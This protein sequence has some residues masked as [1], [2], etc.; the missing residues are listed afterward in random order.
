MLNEDGREA[1]DR[2]ED[3]AVDD[4]GALLALLRRLALGRA[5]G[6]RRPRRRRVLE[7]EPDRQLEVELD[8]GALVLAAEGVVDVEVDLGA[9][10]GAVLGVELPVLARRLLVGVERRGE[11]PLRLV[12]RLELAHVLLGPGG[13]EHV[14]LEAELAVDEVDE[15]QHVLDL[16][17][18][19]LLLAEDVRVVLLEPAHA[20][21]AG[22]GAA[23]LVAV[24][25][26]EV[27]EAPGQLAE[28]AL[29]LGEH[30]AVAGAV[31]GL[32]AEL[33]LLHLEDEHVLAV[34]RG[35]ARRLPQLHV[36]H[37]GRDDLA[38]A[39]LEVLL[40]DGLHQP[41]VDARAVRQPE[42]A[43][44]A[45]LVEEE[46]LLL[47]ADGAVVALLGLLDAEEVLLE[48]L[49]VGEGHAVHAL[50][51]VVASLALP[52]GG[53]VL[54]DGECLDL[55]RVGHVRPAAQVHQVAAAVGRA[56]GA[57]GH[58]ALE[59]VHLEVVVLEH[60]ERLVL[61]HLHALEG[62][63]A[64]DHLVEELLDVLL[65]GAGNGGAAAVDVVVE[66]I[67]DGGADAEVGAVFQ[68]Q[69]EAENVRAGVPE[70][71]ATERVVELAKLKLAVPF[72]RSL[73]VPA[74]SVDLGDHRVLSQALG[75]SHC[76]VEW[77]GLALNS[78]LDSAVRQLNIDGVLGE[79]ST[80]RGALCLGFLKNLHA[81]RNKFGLLA[82][83]KVL[84][85][86]DSGDQGGLRGHFARDACI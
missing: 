86:R 67:L 81:V 54:H 46:E 49:G 76:N 83:V 51:R 20:G 48:L 61:G 33:L 50:Q 82:R 64:L 60:L 16:L 30:E 36:V 10:E 47:R 57:V 31:H 2:P 7:P 85:L 79:S 6:G 66:A 22:E 5:A 43:P 35:V 19:V 32:H 9:V 28:G 39:A 8:G 21:E 74:T 12:P 40:A 24:Q 14:V 37:V 42:A 52:V 25:H 69:G 53:R 17:L 59:H 62:V 73:H 65:V 4:D 58:L 71:L 3:G 70:G 80:L 78:L 77:G 72:Q 29:A 26:A 56:D 15:A 18:D 45:E 13:E 75:N 44:R 63:L 68:L 27:G 41:V 1:L 38:V 23:E 11:L 55:A 84:P 34:V